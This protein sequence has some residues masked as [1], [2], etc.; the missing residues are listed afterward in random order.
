MRLL[1]IEDDKD[2]YDA[3]KK[4]LHQEGYD[5]DVCESGADAEYYLTNGGYNA[6]ILDRLLPGK[7]GLTIL[8][9]MRARGDLTPVLM[10]T[11]LDTVKD[12]TR[13]FPRGDLGA[14]V[15]RGRDGRRRKRGQ[16]RL[17]SAPQA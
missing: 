3:L 10:L 8:R 2:L 13:A 15:G 17:L 4:C 5:C 11:A 9:E 14:R 7:D 16:L 1:L 6:V 12:R